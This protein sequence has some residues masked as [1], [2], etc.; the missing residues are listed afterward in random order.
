MLCSHTT[1]FRPLPSTLT[2]ILRAIVL[3][4]CHHPSQLIEDQY[5]AVCVSVCLYVS[6]T[7]MS[8]S[9]L[10]LQASFNPSLLLGP[11]QSMPFRPVRSQCRNNHSTYHLP[12]ALN[13]MDAWTTR[14][15]S[16]FFRASSLTWVSRLPH[17][18]YSTAFSLCVTFFSRENENGGHQSRENKEWHLS[19][20]ETEER[21][22][23]T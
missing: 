15:P 19:S 6:L 16:V 4:T 12:T 18:Q 13:N 1:L 10:S 2:K 11:S 3:P 5:Q 23:Q 8:A 7:S 22:K 21:G 9:Y 14:H 20:E 17:V